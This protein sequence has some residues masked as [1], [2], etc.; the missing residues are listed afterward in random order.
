MTGMVSNCLPGIVS[1]SGISTCANGLSDTACTSA[2]GFRNSRFSG[3]NLAVNGGIKRGFSRLQ[4]VASLSAPRAK[5][6]LAE[7]EERWQRAL[8]SPLEGVPF[9]YEEFADALSKYDF[10]FEIGDLVRGVV[11]KTDFNGALIDIG[12][13]ASAYLPLSESCIHK[14]KNVEEVGLHPGTEEEFMIVQEDDDNGRVIVSLRKLQYDISWERCRQLQADDCPVRGKGMN[15]EDMVDKELPL[16][17]IEVDEERTRLVLSNRKALAATQL[18]VGI[19]SVVV[20]TVQSVKPYGAFVD[21]GGTSGLLH[22]SQISHDR[23]TTVENVLQPGDKL[24]VMI[25]S[26][27]RDRGRI[28]LSTKKLEPTPGDMLR[29]PALVYEKADEMAKTFRQRVAQAEAAARAEELRLQKEGG[30]GLR[31]LAAPAVDAL[32]LNELDL[33]DIP[34]AEED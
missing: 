2:L 10:S 32:G 12:A 34:P 1:A 23:I 33:D 30:F 28:S 21:I 3:T 24:K 29:N 20:G 25:L 6:L 18:G 27:D 5:D 19:G 13:K 8:D 31:D 17:F 7:A 16:K 15:Q 22:I 26:Q 9:T 14:V 11:F 4:C